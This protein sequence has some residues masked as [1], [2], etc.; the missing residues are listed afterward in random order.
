MDLYCKD[1]HSSFTINLEGS[2]LTADIFS[3]CLGRL[4][5]TQNA[6]GNQPAIRHVNEII[7]YRELAVQIRNF[8]AGFPKIP[9]GGLLGIPAVQSSDGIIALLAA[10][11]AGIPFVMIGSSVSPRILSKLIGVVKLDGF[12]EIGVPTIPLKSCPVTEHITPP[13]DDSIAYVIATSGSSG[14]AKETLVTRHGL[15]SVFNALNKHWMGVLPFG[16]RWIQIHP[17]TFG[18]S[19]CEILGALL[20]GGEIVIVDKQNSTISDSIPQVYDDGS[21]TITCLTPSEFSLLTASKPLSFPSHIILSGE[22]AHKAALTDFFLHP[23]ARMTTVINTY[24]AS[25]TAG[26]ISTIEV[27]AKNASAVSSGLVGNP[28]PDVEV[29]LVSAEGNKISSK[30]YNSVG[31]IYVGGPTV[32]A[33]YLD[34]AHS[35]ERF[36]H[37]S[38]KKFFKTGDL[39][40]WSYEGLYVH[41]RANRTCKLAGQW[42]NLDDIERL[43]IQDSDI[44]EAVVINNPLKGTGLVVDRLHIIVVSKI[45]AE[46]LRAKIKGILPISLTLQV[47]IT[48]AIPRLPN[49]KVDIQAISS[50]KFFPT[51]SSPL[52]ISLSKIVFDTW[53]SILGD[54]VLT[55]VNLFELGL[56]S[57]G[58]TVAA[59]RLS[60]ALQIKISPTF[61]LDHPRID[62]QIL[63]LTEGGTSTPV[64]RTSKNSMAQKRR[65]IRNIQTS[66]E[67]S[68]E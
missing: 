43:L 51:E 68:D 47:T 39:G 52:N 22:P 62:L 6:F 61:L 45:P 21:Q 34:A 2:S 63:G 4:T 46:R 11:A 66:G 56:D 13:A 32:A 7:S 28:L 15:S 30:D 38:D 44:N 5:P 16:K 37:Y 31:E 36:I 10:L 41:G 12:P 48:A 57:L 20:F 23:A 29:I 27:N 9:A 18:F 67:G 42:L 58:L 35:S 33:G 49:G 60:D 24:A 59:C 1:S 14:E 50:N 40:R 65:Q 55:D 3:L 25:E 8:A 17:L 19:L 53:K 26:Q 54:G 64:R